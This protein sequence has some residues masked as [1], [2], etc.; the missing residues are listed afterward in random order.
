MKSQKMNNSY[1]AKT[2]VRGDKLL[3]SEMTAISQQVDSN[4]NALVDLTTTTIPTIVADIDGQKQTLTDI[5]KVVEKVDTPDETTVTK[6]VDQKI[7]DL[8]DGAPEMLDT[9]KELGEAIEQNHDTIEVLDQLVTTNKTTIENLTTDHDQTKQTLSDLNKSAVKYSE[10][11]EGRKTV[12]LANYDSISGVTTSGLGVNLAMVSK[13]DKADFGSAQLPLN[14]NSKDGIVEINDSK[15]VATVDQIPSIDHLATKDQLTASETALQQAIDTK[16]VAGD[17]PEYKKFVAGADPA[18][19]KTIQLAN[20]DSI[21][22]IG[23]DGQ[24][25]NIAMVSK[26]DKVDLGT[27]S[28]TMNLNSKDGFVQIND[29]KIIATVD[30]IPTISHLA[31]KEEVAGVQSNLDIKIESAVQH[32]ETAIDDVEKQIPIIDHLAEKTFVESELAKKVDVSLYDLDKQTFVKQQQLDDYSTTEQIQ[33]KLDQKQPVGDYVV[34]K[35]FNDQLATKVNK[36]DYDVD[37]TTFATKTE[38][39]QS[40]TSIQNDLTAVEGRVEVVEGQLLTKVDQ[41]SYDTFKTD[42][43]S[44]YDD[45]KASVYTKTEVDGKLAGAYHYKGSVNT[46]AELPVTDVSIGDV[47]NVK[48]ADKNHKIK[49]GDNVVWSGEEGWD[50]LSGIVDL[51]AY[52]TTDDLNTAVT[53]IDGKLSTRVEQ[54]AYDADKAT[55]AIKSDVTGLETKLTTSID[56]KLNKTEYQTDKA[57]FAIETSVASRL[58]EKVDVE[59]YQADKATFAIQSDVTAK[60]ATKVDNTTFETEISKLAATESVDTKLATKVN[61][62]E[63]QADKATFALTD[64]IEGKLDAKLDTTTYNA[65]KVTFATKTELDTKLDFAT[66]ASEKSTF[67]LT[68]DVDTKLA[69][70][71]DKTAKAASATAADSATKAAQDGNGDVIADT[72][73]KNSV[74][75]VDKVTFA[76]ATDVESSLATKAEKDHT[77]SQYALA[78]AIPT[79]LPN[80]NALTIKYNSQ[81]AFTY[82]GS[83]SETGNF[84]VNLETVP[85]SDTDTTLAKE[86]IDNAIN[87][88]TTALQTQIDRLKAQIEALHP[89][90]S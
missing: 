51:S 66:Y 5:Q 79:A 42:I 39:Q 57:T 78:S 3:A 88:A 73:V 11:A 59:L 35:T 56:T 22:G 33:T 48:K 67:A 74:Y 68:S 16:Q 24:G 19:R 72:Y 13:W 82:D 86:Y 17:Y 36:S 69:E 12:Q 2:W 20:H 77:H 1:V 27:G 29:D 83:K 31:T 64:D 30:Q 40:V 87:V 54:S 85:V 76:I 62:T 65:D 41:T 14:L 44:K 43:T 9:L 58:A 70:K 37:K 52:A 81:V 8:V 25:Y 10:F 34:T 38:V 23:T 75:S 4:E 32:L 50:V 28:L 49:A 61:S 6:Y 60:L 46:F 15:I 55:F 7:A 71:L 47:Y 53:T 21:S 18:E 80:P 63:Y 45:L 26:W 84:I 90:S 89:V